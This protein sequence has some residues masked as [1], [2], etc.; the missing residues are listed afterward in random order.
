MDNYL[1]SLIKSNDEQKYFA[2]MAIFLGEM[3]SD[4][5]NDNDDRIGRLFS[6]CTP[7]YLLNVSN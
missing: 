4:D 3:F 6:Y 5:A 7:D 1:T 2:N